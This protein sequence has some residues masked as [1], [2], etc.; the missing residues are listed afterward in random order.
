MCKL[1][2]H[3]KILNNLIKLHKNNNLPNKILLNG[4]KGIGKS[5]LINNFRFLSFEKRKL[6]EKNKNKNRKRFH[7]IRPKKPQ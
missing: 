6:V 1:I 7:S 5:L 4:K 3:T 2:G